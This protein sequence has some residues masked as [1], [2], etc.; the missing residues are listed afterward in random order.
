MPSVNH[1]YTNGEVVGMARWHDMAPSHIALARGMV[2][3]WGGCSAADIAAFAE[4]EGDVPLELAAR[5]LS[6]A[7]EHMAVLLEVIDDGMVHRP[8]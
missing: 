5:L 3:G 6:G 4:E 2:D 8:E 1:S 7:L